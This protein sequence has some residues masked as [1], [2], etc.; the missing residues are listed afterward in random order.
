MI[1]N[2]NNIIIDIIVII[3]ILAI[4]IGMS[5][6]YGGYI[7]AII[8]I[9]VGINIYYCIKFLRRR[10][11]KIE[12][13]P[14]SLFNVELSDDKYDRRKLYLVESMLVSSIYITLINI[15]K[16]LEL[17]ILVI[18]IYIFDSKSVNEFVISLVSYLLLTVLTFIIELGFGEYMIKRGHDHG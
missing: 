18:N 16:I 13:V 4:S 8:E 1:N 12:D 10:Y 6:L 7:M 15:F 3:I 2:K 14:K 11:T 5:Y 9:L 17:N